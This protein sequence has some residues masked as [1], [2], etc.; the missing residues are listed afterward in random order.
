M[1]DF[2]TALALVLVIEG[3]I[4]AI[5]PETMQ[6]LAQHPDHLSV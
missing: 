5:M 3:L 1:N 4:Y 6:R 2:L